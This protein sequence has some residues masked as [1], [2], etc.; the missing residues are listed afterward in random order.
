M[1]TGIGN[2]YYNLFGIN[3]DGFDIIGGIECYA[4]DLGLQVARHP[5]EG[6][7]AVGVIEKT[8]TVRKS[9]R[10]QDRYRLNVRGRDT[11]TETD[12]LGS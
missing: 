4:V 3:Q 6:A 8:C 10:A 7:S 5:V 1:S 9:S 11:E 12:S 2:S